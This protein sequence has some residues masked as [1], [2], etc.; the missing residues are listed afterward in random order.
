V[1]DKVVNVLT[2]FADIKMEISGHTDNIGKAESNKELSQKRADAVRQYLIDKG[3]KVERLTT[4][5]FGAEKPIADN[6]TAA[7]KAKNRRTEFKL[8]TG[9]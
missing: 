8:L 3:I 9:N 1:L 5:G 2:D 4:V 6:K 7:G